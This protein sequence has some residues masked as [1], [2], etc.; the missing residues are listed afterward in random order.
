M[1]FHIEYML[2]VIGLLLFAYT[3]RK[4]MLMGWHVRWSQ[5][6][7]KR[8]T[9]QGE[10]W[11]IDIPTQAS[12]GHLNDILFHVLFTKKK[13]L[14][15]AKSITLRGSITGD[16]FVTMENFDPATHPPTATLILQRRNDLP[17]DEEKYMTYRWYSKE[18]IPLRAGEFNVTF[19]LNSKD[20]GGIMGSHDADK[21][22][23]AINDLLGFGLGFGSA[24]GRA[25]GVCTATSA[26]FTLH[27]YTINR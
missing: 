4:K 8:P 13:F 24:G 3:Q 11:Y 2:P 10:G 22:D 1:E 23:E 14:K 5:G 6:V 9:K 21:F 17:R 12:G 25:H 26:R 18:M 20:M 16:G 7:P 19:P 15:G 27:S